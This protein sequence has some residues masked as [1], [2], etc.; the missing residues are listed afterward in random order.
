M[1]YDF[2][3]NDDVEHLWLLCTY[4]FDRD[5]KEVLYLAQYTLNIDCGQL[6]YSLLSGNRQLESNAVH[7]MDRGAKSR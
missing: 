7:G 1:K 2:V 6:V 5:D 4:Y 3:N